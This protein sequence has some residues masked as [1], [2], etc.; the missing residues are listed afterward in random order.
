MT[1]PYAEVIGDP[2][3]HSKSPAIHNFWLGKLGI[4]ADYRAHRVVTGELAAYVH[5]RR[6]DPLWRGCNVTAPHKLA[7][8]ALADAAEDAAREVGAANTLLRLKDGGLMA[9][10]TDVEGFCEGLPDV[11][12]ALAI[13]IGAGGAARACLLALR[14]RG[15]GA[16]TI[17]NRDV[18]KARRLLAELGMVG[19]AMGLG[20][21]PPP[22]DCLINA[23]TLGMVGQPAAPD[24]TARVSSRG[25]VYDLVYA[26]LET[27]LLAA[28][29][30]RGLR[31]ID[32]LEMLVGQAAAAFELFF[33]QPAPREHDAELRGL[34]AS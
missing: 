14:Q 12:G 30:A 27:E 21:G 16:V 23:S 29:R 28:A 25:F 7:G 22:S 8:L 2:V 11:A 5:Q 20:D 19:E 3:A 34:L 10:N 4:D 24:L 15:A 17:V 18:V 33:G 31:T 32:G 9:D 6:S 13:V 26:P 1:R